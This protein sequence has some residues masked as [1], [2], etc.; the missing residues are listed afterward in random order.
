MADEY[1]NAKRLADKQIKKARREGRYPYLPSLDDILD[2]EGYKLSS[3]NLG[4][5]EIPVNDIA[6]TKTITRSNA[7]SCGFM[8]AMDPDSEFAY[9]W[10][11][12]LAYQEEQGI[13]DPIKVYE[14]YKKFYV[15]E[16]NKRVSIMKYLD[17]PTI[18]AEVIR[19][20]PKESDD[21][22]YLLYQEFLQ[23]YQVCPIY[24]ITFTRLHSYESF[25]ELAGIQ[26]NERCTTDEIHAIQG[27]YYRFSKL[28]EKVLPDI[29]E[30]GLTK[31]D[32]LLIYLSMY[33]ADSLL[34]QS[35]A[36]LEKRLLR[37]NEEFLSI[38]N[39]SRIRFVEEP[40][41]SND[42][43]LFNQ[44][45]N[46]VKKYT[47]S[48][49]LR[50]AFLYDSDDSAFDMETGR[51][52]LDNRFEG[53]IH[54]SCYSLC[55]SDIQ[56]QLDKA[57][58]DHNAYIFTTSPTMMKETLKASIDHPDIH[59]LN[60]SINLSHRTVR[61]YDLRS[62]ECKF[63][64]GAL[65]AQYTQKDHIAYL[66]SSP[67]YGDIADIN[68]FA[69]GVSFI[70]PNVKVYLYWLTKDKEDLFQWIKENKIDVVCGSDIP[71]ETDA[72]HTALQQGLFQLQNNNTI[73]N[74][75]SMIL[76]WGKYYEL[77]VQSI[78]DGSYDDPLKQHQQ[79]LN[80][81]YGMKE[82]VIDIRISDDLN[83]R[84]HH[85]IDTLKQGILHDLIDPFAGKLV[86]NDHQIKQETGTLKATDIITMDWLNENI[87][88]SIPDKKEFNEETQELLEVAGINK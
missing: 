81:W 48:D 45:F 87:I 30:I 80:Y 31:G 58:N 36:V 76:N 51:I 56:D 74:L 25:M 15:E 70:D 32:A 65:A 52:Y 24:N 22:S 6:G 88:G 47:E 73:K 75:A 61:T 11:N 28:I 44:F 27:M 46:P 26:K 17:M 21:P 54:T 85:T 83:Y 34:D 1:K 13:S 4:V 77:I 16:G 19:I 37:M 38:A 20:L 29:E 59:F 14:Y 33:T 55:A 66:A 41:D 78:L 63:L 40:H 10:K 42:T 67:V 64:F 39:A 9:K 8:P 57:V 12:V 2:E 3:R 60:H 69:S 7:F 18:E 50:I 49:P 62:Y 86:S 53:I 23:F 79:A 71:L 84:F 68:A 43:N 35:Y 5:V 82:G 72:D